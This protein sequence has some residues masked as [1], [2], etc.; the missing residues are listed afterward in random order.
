MKDDT[1]KTTPSP[2]PVRHDAI[3]L[4]EKNADAAEVSRQSEDKA[5]PDLDSPRKVD[6]KVSLVKAW[7]RKWKVRTYLYLLSFRYLT[8]DSVS[9]RLA[10]KGSRTYPDHKRFSPFNSSTPTKHSI[11][12][13]P[14]S[15][16]SRESGQYSEERTEHAIGMGRIRG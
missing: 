14:F 3:V 8:L 16:K 10:S 1:K 9:S 5:I 13:P 11:H 2:S 12:S 4:S 7:Y 6:R 15:R